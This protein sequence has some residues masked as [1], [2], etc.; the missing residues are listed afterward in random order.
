[1]CVYY[2]AAPRRQTALGMGTGTV[3]CAW[4]EENTAH[5][6]TGRIIAMI[7]L[8]H[9]AQTSFCPPAHEQAGGQAQGDIPTCTLLAIEAHLGTTVHP[10]QTTS[11]AGHPLHIKKPSSSACV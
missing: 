9:H 7:W 4:C 8:W 11:C 1:M 10:G 6:E 3:L 5:P 2:Y